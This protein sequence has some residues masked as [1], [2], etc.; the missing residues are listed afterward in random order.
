MKVLRIL[1]R[2]RFSPDGEWIVFTSDRAGY[3]RIE[4]LERG[5][6]WLL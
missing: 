4:R 5:T 1:K 3:H 6:P 2:P